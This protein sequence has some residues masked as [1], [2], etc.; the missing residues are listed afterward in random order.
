MADGM[1]GNTDADQVE[2]DADQTELVYE[3]N[4]KHREPWQAGK[5]GSLCPPAVRPIAES[6]LQG[7]TLWEGKRYAVHDG[8]A[9]CAQE[10]RP[11]RWHGYPV[12]WVEVPPKLVRQWVK[13]GHLT[14]RDRGRFW[15]MH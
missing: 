13:D 7:S 4:P 6:L 3:S 2:R 8:K 10:H 9:Y 12:G 14:K 1:H 11:N 15:E 5:R